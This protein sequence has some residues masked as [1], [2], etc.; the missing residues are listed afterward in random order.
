MT[1]QRAKKRADKLS[2][3]NNQQCFVI[4][5]KSRALWY[6]PSTWFT[7]FMYHN[8]NSDYIHNHNYKDK[9]YYSTKIVNYG[10]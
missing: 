4:K 8:V 2:V 7:F 9:K 10:D 1:K 6:N 5:I 3:I